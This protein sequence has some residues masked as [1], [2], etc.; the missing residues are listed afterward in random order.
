MLNGW[1]LPR[2]QSFSW[3]HVLEGKK[4]VKNIE[5]DVRM[6]ALPPEL[7]LGARLEKRKLAKRSDQAPGW[8][9]R[10]IK[11]ACERLAS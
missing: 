4:D 5:G 8:D 10:R 9:M 7:H 1:P 2:R 6:G 3:F 11:G